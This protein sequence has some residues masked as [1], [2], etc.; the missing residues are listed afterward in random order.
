MQ[1]Y[2]PFLIIALVLAIA[3]IAGCLLLRS[4]RK[5]FFAAVPARPQPS[6]AV[7]KTEPDIP[8]QSVVTLEEFGDYQCPPCGALHPTLKQLKQQLASNLNF[9]FRNLPLTTIHK[10]SLAA[11]QAAE[12][13][14]MQNRFWEMHDLL[15]ENQNLWADDINP[16]TI[17]LKWAADLGMDMTR[18][19]HDL[20]SQQVKL[21]IE[22]D[23]EAAAELGIS[24]TPTVLVNGRQ[25][26]PE[27]TNAEGIRTAIE[28]V[29]SRKPSPKP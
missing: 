24:G 17:F 19:T 2:R 3:I 16:R 13:A 12:A 1:K 7:S 29:A 14:R 25:L 26:L 18:F 22:A 27:V 9:V 15:Y 8:A 10:N 20:D 23:Q 6:T 4:S 11:A 28:Y 21:R 5:E